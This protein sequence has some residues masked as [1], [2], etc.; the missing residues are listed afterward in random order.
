MQFETNSGLKGEVRTGEG[1]EIEIDELGTKN[2]V[3]GSDGLIY[4]E[5]TEDLDVI[6]Y[7]WADITQEDPTHR[8]ILNGAHTIRRE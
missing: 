6:L 1:L 2:G 5:K 4:I 7:V 3:P 8:I